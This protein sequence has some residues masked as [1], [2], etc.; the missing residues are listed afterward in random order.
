MGLRKELT[1]R[2]G[3]REKRDSN[4]HK[5]G[6]YFFN[7]PAERLTAQPLLQLQP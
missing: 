2:E 3:E 5:F 4:S 6:I 1:N 7:E